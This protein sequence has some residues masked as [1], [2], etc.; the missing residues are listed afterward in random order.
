MRDKLKRMRPR[1]TNKEIWR[2]LAARVATPLGEIQRVSMSRGQQNF[3][4][5]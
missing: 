5:A 1:W 4:V 3:F 2:Y